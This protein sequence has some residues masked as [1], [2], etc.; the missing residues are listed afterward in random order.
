MVKYHPREREDFLGALSLGARL[1]PAAVPAELVYLA[2]ADRLARVIGDRGTT[3]L[4]ARWLAP[5]AQ[6]L[7]ALEPGALDD[8]W[9]A[10][11]LDRLGVR[12]L[13]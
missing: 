3:L 2:S 13:A 8:P 7:S 11:T 9:Y 5:H 10:H 12:R 4:S 6:A 1:L